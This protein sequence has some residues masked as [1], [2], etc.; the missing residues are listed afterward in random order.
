MSA[1]KW[2]TKYD[3]S[4][5]CQYEK[6]VRFAYQDAITEQIL[7]HKII[8]KDGIRTWFQSAVPYRLSKIHYFA[9]FLIPTKR[10][11]L[12]D[13]VINHMYKYGPKQYGKERNRYRMIQS[14]ISEQAKKW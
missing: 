7:K 6:A 12:F 11:F 8:M 9:Q 4:L 14:V 1:F 13:D 3:K 2:A 5:K 10:E